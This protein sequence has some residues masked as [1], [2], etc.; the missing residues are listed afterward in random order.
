MGMTLVVAVRVQVVRH[1][2]AII[3]LTYA[4]AVL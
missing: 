1:D 2:S 3:A 4:T